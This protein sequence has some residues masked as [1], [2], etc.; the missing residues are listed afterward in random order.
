[1]PIG[2]EHTGAGSQVVAGREGDPA[3]DAQLERRVAGRQT[4]VGAR[5]AA[6]SLLWAQMAVASKLG[7]I[8]EGTRP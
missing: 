3:G 2:D 1:M 4:V 6:L 8:G 5:Q 7:R